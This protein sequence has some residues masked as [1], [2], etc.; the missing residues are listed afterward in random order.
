ML[1]FTLPTLNV[2]ANLYPNISINNWPVSSSNQ[3][4]LNAMKSSH[5][6]NHIWAYDIKDN[7]INPL[8]Y[9]EKLASSIVEVFF[10]LIHFHIC[11]LQK[12]IFNAIVWD[13]T[14][15][16]PPLQIA[17]SSSGHTQ[18]LHSILQNRKKGKVCEW[19]I[20]LRIITSLIT[21]L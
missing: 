3:P 12:N 16:R 18:N 15:L 19:L 13:I 9:Q 6:V 1:M 4:Y 21:T 17:S 2:Y 8:D 7:L 10:S 20:K 11:Q 5:I 14:V